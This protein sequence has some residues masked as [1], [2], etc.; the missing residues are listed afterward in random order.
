MKL[1]KRID[2]FISRMDVTQE[3][4]MNSRQIDAS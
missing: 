2:G 1:K 3:R 4:V